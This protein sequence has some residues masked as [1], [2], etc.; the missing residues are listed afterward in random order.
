MGSGE[1]SAQKALFTARRKKTK[2][3]LKEM[4]FLIMPHETQVEKGIKNSNVLKDRDLSTTKLL[5]ILKLL[6]C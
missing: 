2:L 4:L 6:H 1:N 5:Q 3:E